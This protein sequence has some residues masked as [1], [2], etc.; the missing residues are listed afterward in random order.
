MNLLEKKQKILELIEG[1]L[2]F[3]TKKDIFAKKPLYE[4]DLEIDNLSNLNISQREVEKI[5]DQIS[6]ENLIELYDEATRKIG[7]KTYLLG[8]TVVVN[9]SEFLK[10]IQ[11]VDP[12]KE[13]SSLV[14][15]HYNLNTGVGF[16]DGNTFRFQR[17]TDPF[18][19]FSQLYKNINKPIVLHDL[20]SMVQ[21]KTK[22]HINNMA[23]QIRKN[24]G[25]DTTQL[26][27]NRG[28]LTLVGTKKKLPP[29][30]NQT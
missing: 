28:S 6:L 25:L 26:V 16:V 10:K 23:K 15:V 3:V 1:E 7:I 30:R 2:H 13:Q 11:K 8:Y 27:Q 19:I 20:L 4:I 18:N 9:K 12:T 21:N 22:Y 29:K 24:T 14:N 5:L 17:S